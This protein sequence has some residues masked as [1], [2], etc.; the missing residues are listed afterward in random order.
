MKTIY[1][2][3]SAFDAVMHDALFQE[4]GIDGKILC[5]PRIMQS[6]VAVVLER[7]ALKFPIV[8]DP[9]MP[10]GRMELRN[11]RGET[12]AVIESLGIPCYSLAKTAR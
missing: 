7:T 12:L 1:A 8:A 9:E 10:P 11:L 6:I 3:N 4:F 5:V 2:F